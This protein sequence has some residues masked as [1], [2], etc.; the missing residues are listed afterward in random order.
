MEFSRR[1]ILRCA[2][3]LVAVTALPAFN[4]RPRASSTTA[5]SFIDVDSFDLKLSRALADGF[6]LV[7]VSL[8]IQTQTQVP[9]RLRAWLGATQDEDGELRYRSIP[10][11]SARPMW[12][13]A[14]ERILVGLVGP[15]LVCDGRARLRAPTR[16]YNVILVGEE[17]PATA[18]IATVDFYRRGSRHFDFE[19]G[20]SKRMKWPP[21]LEH[22]FGS[23]NSVTT[24]RHAG[25]QDGGSFR[26]RT[27]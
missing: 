9:T 1:G 23:W 22:R 7:R 24:A 26:Q 2:A 17:Y 3:S 8:P 21:R 11:G 15:T 12:A 19:L 4:T 16:N 20:Q 25:I 10:S 27:P 13:T 5:I 18:R 6:A 14:I